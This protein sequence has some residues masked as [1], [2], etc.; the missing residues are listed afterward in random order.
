MKI[1]TRA[2]M[3]ELDR[4]TMT[5]GGI[6]EKALIERA[7]NA[8]AAWIG[9]RHH[10]GSSRFLVIAGR[11][12]NGADAIVAARRLRESGFR[13][14]LLKAW[15]K[16]TLKTLTRELE[17]GQGGRRLVIVDGLFGTGLNRPVEDRFRALILSLR[18]WGGEVIALD[19]P[20]GM[21]ADTGKAMGACV[22]ATH[23]L[24][25]GL[26]KFGLV[27]ERAADDV[28]VL[29]ALDIGFPEKFV[30]EIETPFDLITAADVARS[31]EPRAR[32]SHK[33]RFG[34]VLVVAGSVGL[35]GAAAL[36]ARAALRAGAGLVSLA[37]PNSIYAV[38]AGLAG[39]EVMTHPC[40]D[41]V[42]CFSERSLV[43][44]KPLLESAT[45]LV[46]GPGIGEGFAVGLV[47]RRLIE[48]CRIPLVLDAGGLNALDGKPG[49]L[50]KAL[51]DVVI[52]PH[53]G[54]MARLTGTTVRAV[55]TD[56]FETSRDFA[57]KNRVTVVLKGA[58]T[59][60]AHPRL[61]RVGEGRQGFRWS[62]NALAGNPGMATAGCGDALAGIVGALLA[63]GVSAPGAARGGVFLHAMAG[64]VAMSPQGGG[65][66][67]D[68]IDALPH[69]MAVLSG[70]V[71][72]D[73]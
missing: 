16:G 19:L 25:F 73:G 3:R 8:A 30:D 69:A 50:K 53:P 22:R 59:V 27:K 52:T 11:G 63:R 23:T 6:S 67:G 56:R 61:T 71:R 62:V 29:H 34:H 39:A 26:S 12:N 33:G 45:A 37:V 13:A 35:A 58:R 24:T 72:S 64:D 48:G 55:Q 46:L 68:L 18:A 31:L 51:A 36:A 21:N 1:V 40:P 7:G 42:G 70:Q 2:Q 49:V 17:R 43:K 28:G 4:R 20:S 65:I 38:A 15:K 9:H 10:P 47:V 54:E 32:A 60:V 57:M 44:L 14:P 41:A 5:E 66:A